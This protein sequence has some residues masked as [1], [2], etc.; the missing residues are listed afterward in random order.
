MKKLLVALS[1]CCSI[2][3]ADP[4]LDSVAENDN[5][6]AK[7]TTTQQPKVIMVKGS[8][9]AT[10]SSNAHKTSNAKTPKAHHST[11]KHKSKT[12]TNKKQN[13]KYKTKKHTAKKS[14]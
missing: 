2:A 11:N 7:P 10:T 13:S 6:N 5:T 14:T 9:A 4:A 3:I 12:K 8:T 1:V